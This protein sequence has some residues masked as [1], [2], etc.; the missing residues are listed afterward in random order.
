MSERKRVSYPGKWAAVGLFISVIWF[1]FLAALIGLVVVSLTLLAQTVIYRHSAATVADVS[2]F[3]RWL[4]RIP[5]EAWGEVD[6]CCTV[7]LAAFISAQSRWTYR[8]VLS[9]VLACG[10]PLACMILA[11]LGKAPDDVV[12]RTLP[13]LA[14]CQIIVSLF[15]FFY[16]PLASAG[17]GASIGARRFREG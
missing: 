11:H 2:A 6:V 8:P 17:V 16:L 4:I 13:V 7:F 3:R 14:A 10:I 15:A 1:W 12:F 5:S 9:A